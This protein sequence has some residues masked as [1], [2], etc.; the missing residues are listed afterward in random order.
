MSSPY[1][2]Q[3][4]AKSVDGVTGS[5]QPTEFI[6]LQVVE[7]DTVSLTDD[8]IMEILMYAVRINR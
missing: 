5:S 7:E 1:D 3:E 4:E 6:T 8:E 2:P